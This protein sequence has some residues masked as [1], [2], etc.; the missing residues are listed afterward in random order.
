MHLVLIAGGLAAGALLTFLALAWH[1]SDR[2]AK[3][4]V[5]LG[6]VSG[7]WINEQRLRSADRHH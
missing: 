3:A 5:D 2:R 4:D 7:Q 6:S 1:R